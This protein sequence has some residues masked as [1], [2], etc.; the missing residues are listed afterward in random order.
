MGSGISY[1]DLLGSE[2][3]DSDIALESDGSQHVPASSDGLQ[4]CYSE[5]G[6]QDVSL[7]LSW[8]LEVGS[9][10]RCTRWDS[11]AI[12]VFSFHLFVS[13]CSERLAPINPII[14]APTP[15]IQ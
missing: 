5:L 6:W 14:G 8:A 15:L 10:V 1:A 9:E 4:F 12:L 3:P 13:S 2:V 7:H 11:M